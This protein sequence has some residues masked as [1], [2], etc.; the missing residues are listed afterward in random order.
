M[1]S[2]INVNGAEAH[3]VYRYLRCKSE[4]YDESSG[5]AKEIPWNFAK[6]LV[7]RSG[8]VVA[9]YSPQTEPNHLKAMIESMLK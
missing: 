7:D 2:K 6:F 5:K 9:Y 1:F 4:L 8:K 3:P